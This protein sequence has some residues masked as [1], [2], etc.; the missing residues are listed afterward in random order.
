M[1][2]K[3]T[4]KRLWQ[5]KTLLT[6]LFLGLV[7]MAIADSYVPFVQE[8]RM[9]VVESYD[10]P[11]GGH[12]ETC[13]MLMGDTIIDGHQAKK[14]YLR[15]KQGP[16][17]NC[18]LFEENRKVYIVQRGEQEATLLYDFSL[19]N[20]GDTYNEGAKKMVLD[21]VD[22]VTV[23]DSQYRRLHLKSYSQMGDNLYY[24]GDVVWV[25]GIGSTRIG[26]KTDSYTTENFTLLGV[27]QDGREIFTNADFERPAGDDYQSPSV[28][29]DGK[30]W[31]YRYIDFADEA[32]SYDYRYFLYGDTVIFGLTYRKLYRE[33]GNNDGTTAFAAALFEAGKVV[34]YYDDL[35]KQ[36][37]ALYDF[38]RRQHTWTNLSSMELLQ[39]A[40]H[41]PVTVNGITRDLIGFRANATAGTVDGYWAEGIGSCVDFLTP[42]AFSPRSHVLLKE[43]RRDG[44]TLFE[45]ADFPLT[46]HTPLPQQPRLHYHAML[47]EGKK[48][49]YQYHHFEEWGD[50]EHPE[51]GFGYDET[52]S[53]L[54]YVLR[55]DTVVNGVAA[56][57]M[58]VDKEDGSSSYYGAW[59][60]QDRKVYF[61]RKDTQEQVLYFDFSM[62]CD[63]EFQSREDYY[64]S[65][66]LHHTDT[67]T[68][69]GREYNHFHFNECKYDFEY[70]QWMEGMGK[71]G[72]QGGILFPEL[73]KYFN[74]I[75]DYQSF[76]SCHED[77]VQI[78]P[79]LPEDLSVE[80]TT[81]LAD[82]VGDKGLYDMTGRRLT[83]SKWSNGQ[84]PKGVYI[85]DGRK[86]V[87]K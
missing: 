59:A 79:Q 43:C 84:M 80:S 11:F 75:C 64:T 67:L 52:V 26:I 13:L 58:Y 5:R 61:V 1:R 54:V 46:P 7:Q 36:D 62:K 70:F 53:D 14:G 38:S 56:H 78:Y 17:Y 34:F 32:K 45:L 8:G 68:V 71:T 63:Q 6:V 21:Q 12:D 57:K 10:K 27:M 19:R 60:E 48:W 77:G 65:F 40:T 28:L 87:V 33:N 42:K 31:I 9:L 15:S 24:G 72:E 41:D 85:R 51:N 49:Q 22:Y 25:E 86:V 55:G 44:Q 30:E 16:D 18:A 50:I 23:K 76:V 81:R 82:R 73:V 66:Y 2:R 4:R 37:L 39:F 29:E 35:L 20:I 83:N 69:N 47:K 74:C 3:S